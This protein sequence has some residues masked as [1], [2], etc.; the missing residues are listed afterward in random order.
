[1]MDNFKDELD[2]I[3]VELYEEWKDLSNAESAKLIGERAR[4]ITKQYHIKIIAESPRKTNS[5]D[6]MVK[7]WAEE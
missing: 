5:R 6:S 3:R 2:K 4:K 1:M 7:Q